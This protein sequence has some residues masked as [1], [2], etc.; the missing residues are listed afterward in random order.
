MKGFKKTALRVAAGALFCVIHVSALASPAGSMPA[1]LRAKSAGLI[2][3]MSDRHAKASEPIIVGYASSQG[4]GDKNAA[5]VSFTL[6]SMGGGNQ[7]FQYLAAFEKED[8]GAQ[9]TARYRLIGVIAMGGKAWR[10]VDP[11]SARVR[12]DRVEFDALE[13][14]PSDPF[15][16]PTR[17]AR[18]GYRLDPQSLTEIAPKARSSR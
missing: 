5:L 2:A 7:Y 8:E 16:C 1:E 9:G 18:A 17:K 6:E 4:E 12:G 14:A 15:C 10:S 3:L 11:R 13:Y